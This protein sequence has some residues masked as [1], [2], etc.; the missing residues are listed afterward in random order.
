MTE[1]VGLIVLLIQR[2]V[3]AEDVCGSSHSK[4]QIN[5][6]SI[7]VCSSTSSRFDKVV[8]RKG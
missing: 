2:R 6:Q 1:A 7:N 3:N 5:M 8:L 4:L